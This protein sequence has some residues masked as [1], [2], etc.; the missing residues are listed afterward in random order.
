MSTFLVKLC[1]LLF[2]QLKD[3]LNW[4]VWIPW[5]TCVYIFFNF[6]EEDEQQR[7]H[8]RKDHSRTDAEE[9]AKAPAACAF[10]HEESSAQLSN[11]EVGWICRQGPRVC[12][13]TVCGCSHVR[14]VVRAGAQWSDR[15]NTAAAFCSSRL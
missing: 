11:E 9:E 12:D 15:Q 5:V 3:C 13:G 14:A 4:E 6:Q 10:A 8:K 1:S 2:E 7:F